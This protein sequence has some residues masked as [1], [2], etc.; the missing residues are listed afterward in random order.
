M[1]RNCREGKP[2]TPE[3]VLID[4]G[5]ARKFIPNQINSHTAS[6]T[7]CYAPIEQ[8]YKRHTPGAYTD[9]YGLAATLYSCLTKA[10]P[11]S[12]LERAE[13]VTK[14]KSDP[15]VS[16]QRINSN[17][18]DQVNRAILKGMEIDPTQRPQSVRKWLALL[19]VDSSNSFRSVDS[20]APTIRI[21][22]ISPFLEF[23]KQKA[24]KTPSPHRLLKITTI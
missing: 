4:F 22:G 11:E 18:S 23:F 1:L 20:E 16:P 15:L 24:P 5:T 12:A 6:V 3:A 19:E 17:L 14:K 21:P 8:Y 7:P 10:L 9:V 2:C 13:E